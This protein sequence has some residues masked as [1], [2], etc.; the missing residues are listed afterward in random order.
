MKTI[1]T[2]CTMLAT[3]ALVS[4]CGGDDG[5]GKLACEGT[6]ACMTAAEC[7]ESALT[8]AN[9]SNEEYD[10]PADQICCVLIDG[11]ADGG[12]DD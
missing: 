3:L 11:G 5:G 6:G 12:T 4:G 9:P 10:C 8:P 1:L 2:V 7:S